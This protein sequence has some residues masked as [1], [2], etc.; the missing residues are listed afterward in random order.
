MEIL[1]PSAAAALE[2][3]ELEALD[4]DELEDAVLD[5]LEDAEVAVSV[6]VTVVEDSD[7]FPPPKGRLVQAESVAAA[8]RAAAGASSGRAV[9]ARE[10]FMGLTSFIWTAGNVTERNEVQTC[11]LA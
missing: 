10:R 1:R 11:V 6:A 9:K 8:V 5:A 4:E 3:D 2:D 7:S